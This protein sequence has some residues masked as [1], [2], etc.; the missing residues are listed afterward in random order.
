M[1][2]EDQFFANQGLTPEKEE[3]IEKPQ[4]EEVQQETQPTEQVESSL[5]NEKPLEK[6]EEPTQNENTPTRE[7]EEETF[8]INS[9]EDLAKFASTHF[10]K[11]I[12]VERLKSIL[13][14]EKQQSNP[15]ANDTVKEVNDYLANGG[16][17][18][19]FIEFKMT[20]FTQ[21]S[22]LEIVAKKMQADYPTLTKAQI[23]RKISRQFKL[24]ED[25]YDEEEIE[26]GKIDLTLAAQ[27]SRNHFLA[28]QQ[29][30]ASPLQTK[31]EAKAETPE[32][33]DEQIQEFNNNMT[34]SVNNLKSFE[35]N[36]IKYEVDDSLRNK[37]GQSPADIGDLF[38][39]GDKFNFDK[40]NQ[41]RAIAVDPERFAKTLYEQG[42]S[43]ALKGL[44]ESRNNTS[45][46]AETHR[47]DEMVDSKKANESL[48]AHYAG[49]TKYTL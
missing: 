10:G 41:F 47:P 45:L 43:D 9:D 25:R 44:K 7:E 8:E 11:D 22:D 28:Q 36:G 46:E 5:D 26:D 33:T 1:D 16:D 6:T 34:A 15:F 14:D 20:D 18:K 42:K 39:E 49:Q 4:A 23:D 17:L 21:M 3:V 38:L 13:E 12:S 27:E 29:K 24:D 40:Y 31:V 35:V 30:F 2:F 37:V 19:D 32:F 48:L